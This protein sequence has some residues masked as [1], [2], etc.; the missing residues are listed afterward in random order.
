MRFKINR[1]ERSSADGEFVHLKDF[2][3]AV[4][5]LKSGFLFIHFRTIN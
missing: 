4:A 3:V 2:V 5:V 1:I